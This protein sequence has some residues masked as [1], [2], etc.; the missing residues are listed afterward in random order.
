MRFST[1]DQYCTGC[2][3]RRRKSHVFTS[4]SCTVPTGVV[5]HPPRSSISIFSP[6]LRLSS[7]RAMESAVML[8]PKSVPTG[9]AYHGALRDPAPLH[10]ASPE[11][12]GAVVGRSRSTV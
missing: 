1:E 11:T 3:L 7:A 6:L 5:H 4:L 8:R 2:I 9:V 10:E 12:V